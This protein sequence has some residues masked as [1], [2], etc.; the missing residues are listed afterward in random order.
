MSAKAIVKGSTLLSVII[1]LLPSCYTTFEASRFSHLK[2]V[3]SS[4]GSGADMTASRRD[5]DQLKLPAASFHSIEIPEMEEASLIQEAGRRSDG[6]QPESTDLIKK[7]G[8]EQK[9]TRPEYEFP[10][11]KFGQSILQESRELR[12]ALKPVPD[13]LIY[14]QDKLLVLWLIL[15]GAAIVFGLLT[16]VAWPFSILATLA[17]I[18]AIV[19]F[20]LWI[21]NIARS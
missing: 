7:T 5:D 19:F 6:S 12:A 13:D 2:Y 18:A 20:V 17:A 3:K 14:D 1:L 10:V 16:A 4:K 21:V 9:P 8:P 11:K 15:T